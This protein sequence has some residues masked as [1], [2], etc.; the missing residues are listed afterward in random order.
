M[1][2]AINRY[3]KARK[4]LLRSFG[5]RQDQDYFIKVAPGC[6]WEI[7]YE[8]DVYILSY[9]LNV[10]EKKFFICV[11]SEGKPIV[12]RAREHTLV[13]AIDCVKTAFVLDNEAEAKNGGEY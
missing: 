10:N 12:H 5:C 8:G 11:R 3:L 2:G 6:S 9:W 7:K 13:V 1:S 4:D